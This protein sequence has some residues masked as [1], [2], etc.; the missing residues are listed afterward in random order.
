[1]LLARLF[2]TSLAPPES[3]EA[4]VPASVGKVVFA[5]AK[6]VWLYLVV[7]A[8]GLLW[9]YRPSLAACAVALGLTVVTLCAGHSVGLH[10][11]IIHQTYSCPRWL[12][13]ALA[14]AFAHT[15]IGGPIGWIQL[16]YV[17]DHHQNAGECPRYFR[18]DHSL[19]RDYFWNLHLRFVPRDAAVYGFPATDERDPWLRFL[20]RTWPAHVIA[21]GIALW[22]AFGPGVALVCVPLR[23]AVSVLGHWFV[24]FTAHKRGAIRYDLDGSAEIG[25]NLPILGVL[26]FG[27]GFHNN[28][29]ANPRSAR[30][31]ETALQLDLGWYLL[32]ALERVGLVRDLQATGR[33]PVQRFN[34]RRRPQTTSTCPRR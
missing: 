4:L 30:M 26:S 16:H 2:Q 15:G 19:L 13:G 31:G 23:V 32:L 21:L 27:E 3:R 29:H 20:E 14:Y 7:G 10:R 12:R 22:L 17:R 1:M 6:V 33:T 24:G 9:L 5:P 8:S 25:R 11:G 28:H 18:Y 34:A